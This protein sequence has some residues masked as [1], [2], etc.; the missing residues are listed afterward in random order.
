MKCLPNKINGLEIEPVYAQVPIVQ[1][2]G[3]FVH[4]KVSGYL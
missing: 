4:Y 3:C 1:G 2:I